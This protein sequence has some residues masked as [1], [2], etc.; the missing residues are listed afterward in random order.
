MFQSTGTSGGLFGAKP[1]A[2]PATGGLF[3]NTSAATATPSTPAT[4]SGLF[5]AATTTTAKPT[6]N[7]LGSTAAPAAQTTTPAKSLFGG[8]L[9]TTA[10][11]AT[12]QPASTSGTMFSTTPAP[13]AASGGLFGGVS[14]TATAAPRLGAFGQTAPTQNVAAQPQQQQQT[15]QAVRLDMNQVRGTTKF[16]DLAKEAQDGIVKIDNMISVIMGWKSEIEGFLPAHEEQIA[17]LAHD[18]TYL[19]RKYATVQRA[20]LED[21]VANIQELRSMSNQN[22]ADAQLASKAVD[23][24]KLPIS[25]HVPGLWTQSTS[26]GSGG[27]DPTGAAGEPDLIS[28]FNRHITIL[29]ERD[30]K[31]RSYISEIQSH[32]PRVEHGLYEKLTQL[33]AT[34]GMGHQAGMLEQIKV[35]LVDLRDTIVKQAIE[36][37]K[38]REAL[39]TLEQKMLGRDRI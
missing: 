10:T 28:Y 25:Y 9:N 3:G 32:M 37:A 16:E 20:V 7:L 13:A 22:I 17:S 31:L 15:V 8:A 19:E 30:R 33:Q 14:G 11:P 36:V 6:L 21:D 4:T 29:G 39:M 35:V 27:P 24:L 23:N 26:A 38:T 34:P 1:A 2:T 18:V 5:G 12:T